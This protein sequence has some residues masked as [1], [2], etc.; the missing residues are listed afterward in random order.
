MATSKSAFELKALKDGIHEL[1]FDLPG[2]KVNKLGAVVMGELKGILQN[3]QKKTDVKILLIKSAKPNIFIA[4]ADI[5]EIENIRTPEDAL[6]KAHEGQNIV[7]MIETLPFPTVAV[8]D[9]ACVGGGLEFALSCT[10]RVASD[11]PK[12]QLGLPEVNLG[13]IPGWGGTQRLPKLVGLAQ[14]LT[15]ILT[16]K[17]LG[18]AQ[19]LKAHLVDACYPQAFLE[20]RLAE[21][22]ARVLDRKGRSQVMEAR[23]IRGFMPNFLQSFLGRGMVYSASKKSVMAATRGFYPAPL[24]ALQV[25]KATYGGGLKRGLEIERKAFGELAHGEISKNLVRIFFTSEALRKDPGAVVKAEAKPVESAAV[26]GAGVMGGGIAWLFSKSDISV[27]MKDLNWKAIGKGYEAAAQNYAYLKKTRKLDERQVNLK[28]HHISGTTDFSGFENIDIV[29]EAVV[30]DLE[31]KKKVLAETESHIRKDAV[32]ATNTSSLAVTDMAKGLKDPSRFV[33][34]HFFNPV[35]R[36]PLVEVVGG[37][38]SSP[39]AIAFTVALTKKLGKTP[40]VVKDCAG[41]LVN[42]ILLP[43]L[44]EAGLLFQEGAKVE[45]VDKLLYQFGMPMGPFTLLDEIGI[46]VGYKVAKILEKAYSDRMKAAEILRMAYE[47]KK[48]TGKKGGKGFYIHS[49]SGTKTFNSEANEL[50][51]LY[52]DRYRI[53]LKPYT[54]DDILDRC[55][56]SMA[57]EAARCVE[58]KIAAGPAYLDMALILGTGF[59]PHR[60][61]ILRYVDNRGVAEVVERLKVLA[62]RYGERFQPAKLLV[63]MARKKEKFYV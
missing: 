35:N 61:G 26:L 24:A 60:G 9:G 62:S 4:G 10:Y 15:M 50:F 14:G 18:G 59:P 47:E 51:A 54:D 39:E 46:D 49:A 2:E 3:L 27:R 13:I 5:N 30:E 34:M 40:I 29:I 8:I 42:R 53:Q 37:K 63:D 44:N 32:L 23:R 28:M 38:Q 20:D 48:W 21:F 43:Y 33:G 36:M 52:L 41:F 57:N 6:E 11:N 12:T 55:L 1:V 7:G 31:I 45:Q 22:V 25:V 17:Y 56:L 19:A 16:G 58:E